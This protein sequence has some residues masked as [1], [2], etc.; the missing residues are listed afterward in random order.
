MSPKTED[1]R[2]WL[3]LVRCA[4]FVLSQSLREWK[5][6]P[7]R[8]LPS[9]TQPREYFGLLDWQGGGA[10]WSLQRGA[11]SSPSHCPRF[12]RQRK[13]TLPQRCSTELNTCVTCLRLPSNTPPEDGHSID[14]WVLR[15]TNKVRKI[16][17]CQPV[18][19]CDDPHQTL[20]RGQTPF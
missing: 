4:G 18:F 11:A 10:L 13:V 3:V 12:V 14:P 2:E 8:P 16:F 7:F 6:F 5:G 1:P 19:Q 20:A 9:P 15:Y 17:F